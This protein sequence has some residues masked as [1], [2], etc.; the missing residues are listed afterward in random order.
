MVTEFKFPDVGE[1][2]TEGEIVKW[3]V[4]EGD[5]VK[6]H[7][8]IVEVETD[9]AIVEIPAPVSGTILK[10]HYKEGDTVEVGKV[11]VTLGTTGETKLQRKESVAVVGELEEAADEEPQ[12]KKPNLPA[13]PPEKQVLAMP[14]VRRVAAQL[15]VDIT[16]VSGTGP[17]GMITEL[18]VRKAA[19]FRTAAFAAA[20]QKETAAPS[21]D[22]ERIP[23]HGIRKVIAQHMAKSEHTAVHVSHFDEADVTE[24]VS[25]REKEKKKFEGKGIKLTYIPFIVKALVKALKEHPYLN[26]TLDDE[27]E[28]I[29]IK[30]Y[31]NIGIAVDTPEGLIVP[32]IKDAG[33]KGIEELAKEIASLA[34]RAKERKNDIAELK[35]GTFTITNIGVL[36]GTHFTPIIN[37]PE[38]AILGIGAIKDSAVVKD[39]KIVA[40]KMLPLS[41]SFDHRV[42]DG[43][44]A[45]RFASALKNYLENVEMLLK[46]DKELPKLVKEEPKKEPRKDDALEGII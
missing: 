41:I 40:R 30:R 1:G 35:G 43:A 37:W 19:V 36:G 15:S 46:E 21:G 25:Y 44:E 29:I 8:V 33:K 12:A 14:A 45:A 10:L 39:G 11:L 28:E 34:S 18:D 3:R 31:Y 38:V 32:N 17:G 9:K 7:D 2:I 6:E 5:A 20:Q 4:K 26:A 24:L 13:R 16:K 23:L 42:L 27:K 22:A